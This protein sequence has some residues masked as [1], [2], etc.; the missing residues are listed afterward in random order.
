MPNFADQNKSYPPPSPDEYGLY[1]RPIFSGSDP[2]ILTVQLASGTINIGGISGSFHTEQPGTGDLTAVPNSTSTI[3]IAS[4]NMGRLGLTIFNDCSGTLYLR[5]GSG[6]VAP[7]FFSVKL[8]SQDF[9]ELQPPTYTG[10][11]M[12]MWTVSDPSGNALVTE[13]IP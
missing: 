6:S 13:F 11:V 1:V 3:V 2:N 9:W 4:G 8:A 10:V 7:N 5:C 12:G